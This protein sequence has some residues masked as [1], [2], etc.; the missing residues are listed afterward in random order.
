MLCISKEKNL[1]VGYLYNKIYFEKAEVAICDVNS[2]V[3]A[4]SRYKNIKQ[5]LSV[6]KFDILFILNFI[7]IGQQR[8]N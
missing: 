8:H 7:T 2:A 1:V 5:L 4:R 6:V 3:C